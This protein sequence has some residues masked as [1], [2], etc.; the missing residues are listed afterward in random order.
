MIYL[1]IQSRIR[2]LVWRSDYKISST[3]F[4]IH[5]GGEGRCLFQKKNKDD[6]ISLPLPTLMVSGWWVCANVQHTSI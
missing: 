3:E 6:C 2:I 4:V 1:Q 5:G